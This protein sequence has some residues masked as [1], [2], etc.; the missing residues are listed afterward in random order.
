MD[1]EAV[2]QAV[3]QVPADNDRLAQADW[4]LTANTPG[5]ASVI[6]EFRTERPIYVQ[7][8]QGIDLSLVAY[9]QETTDGTGGNTETFPLDEPIIKSDATPHNLVL[10]EGG[11]RVQ[12]D[13]IDYGANS[14]DYTDDGTNNTLHVYH[15][16]NT[17]AALRLKKVAPNNTEDVLLGTDTSLLMQRQPTKDP[18]AIN[19]EGDP[20]KGIVPSKWRVQFVLDA[21]WQFRW[22]DDVGDGTSAVNTVLSLPVRRTSQ[23]VE[24]LGAAIR[25]HASQR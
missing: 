18:V 4:D 3:N 21:P 10:F 2:L 14:F 13:S 11:Q 20:L 17:Q 16:T 7:Q 9:Q 25:Q 23:K 8:G 24:G 6:A 5:E 22:S 1:R 15:V 19:H 12:P